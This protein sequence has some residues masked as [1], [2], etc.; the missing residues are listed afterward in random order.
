MVQ[1]AVQKEVE[2]ARTAV[3]IERFNADGTPERATD[4]A[5]PPPAK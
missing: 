4:S 1:A 5:E 3:K 2:A